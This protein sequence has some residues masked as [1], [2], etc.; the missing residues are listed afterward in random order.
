MSNNTKD[1][2]APW[3]LDAE[4]LFKKFLSKYK[5]KKDL[6]FIEI[7]SYEGRGT[8]WLLDN[9]L[10]SSSATITCL[11]TWQG[12]YEHNKNYM[13][14]V[15]ERFINNTK[16]HLGKL[17]IIKDTSYNGLLKLQNN[18]EYYDFIYIDGGHTM[19][20][21]LQDAILSFPL[22]KK[23]GI[24]AFDDYQWSLNEP[25]HMRPQQGVNAFVTAYQAELNVLYL[26]HQVWLEKK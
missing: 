18:I 5:G 16:E 21:V 14:I 23:G 6:N 7:G 25:V 1:F 12:G 26:G 24:I 10:T 3:F 9:I 13:S 11:D 19:K 22:I 2:E 8:C 17:K 20:D 15:E 4:P